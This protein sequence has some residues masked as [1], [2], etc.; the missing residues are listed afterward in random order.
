MANTLWKVAVRDV[1]DLLRDVAARPSTDLRARSE[2]EGRTVTARRQWVDGESTTEPRDK[3]DGAP[4]A[5]VHRAGRLQLDSGLELLAQA[6]ARNRL[7]HYRRYEI[8]DVAADLVRDSREIVQTI[9]D[10]TGFTIGDAEREVARAEQTLRISGEEAKRIHGEMV[11]LHGAPGV[12]GRLAFTVRH[13]VR[14]SAPS[15]FNSSHGC[16]QGRGLPSLPAT[17][18][19]WPSASYT[20]LTATLLVEILIEAGL[21]PELIA[22]VHGG[23]STVGQWLLESPVPAFYAFT[24]STE[25]GEHIRQ[26][27]GL[28]RTQLELGSL[29]STIVCA[30]ADLERAAAAPVCGSGVPQRLDRSALRSNAFTSSERLPTSSPDCWRPS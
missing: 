10:D 22:L 17:P 19:C 23:G 16:P 15:P 27:V 21:P 3:F 5:R 30:D 11:P 28:R 2:D 7:P 9:V 26:E 24:G 13:P 18:C 12:D 4:I 29:A 1:R 20:P 25:V 14:L 6:Q 8:L